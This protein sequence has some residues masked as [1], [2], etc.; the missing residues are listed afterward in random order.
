L[1]HLERRQLLA[2]EL[3]SW[4]CGRALPLRAGAA[5]QGGSDPAIALVEAGPARS[6]AE[7]PCQTTPT[8]P[9]DVE[10]LGTP[11]C[12]SP[13]AVEG[14]NLTSCA[15]PIEA[16]REASAA[17]L[18]VCAAGSAALDGPPGAA[19]SDSPGDATR[20]VSAAGPASSDTPEG[21]AYAILNPDGSLAGIARLDL[22]GLLRPR[23]V[24]DAAG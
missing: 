20:T 22:A 13:G 6:I 7:A 5:D 8:T 23:L 9:G 3:P 19:A 14:L 17:G 21:P 10:V 18:H 11:A 4:R 24:F 15:T 16:I 1:S 12:T 2:E